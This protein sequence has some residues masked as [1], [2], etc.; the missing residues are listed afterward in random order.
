VRIS[1]ISS[2]FVVASIFSKVDTRAAY[3]TLHASAPLEIHAGADSRFA[4]F[5]GDHSTGYRLEVFGKDGRS[6]IRARP[7]II[8]TA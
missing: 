1:R 8:R 5:P 7:C 4:F 6:D 3:G 2:R